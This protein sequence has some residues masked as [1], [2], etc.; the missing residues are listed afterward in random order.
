MSLAVGTRLG[1]YE[2]LAPLGAGGM[3]EV[4]RARDT[5]LDRDV[6][7]KILPEA[8]AADPE[9]LA[10]FQREAK[11]LA[12]LNHPNIGQI[13]GLE[14]SVPATA[15][16]ARI[17]GLVLELVEGDTL[18]AKL[19]GTGLPVSEALTIARQIADALDAAHGKAIV[20]RDLKPANIKITPSGTVKVLDFG[21][22]KAVTDDQWH[23]DLSH[24][25][26]VSALATRGGVIL[27]TAAYMSPEQA[28]GQVVDKRTDIWAFGCVLFE[29]LTGRG[30]FGR[31]TTSDTIAAVLEHEPDWSQCPAR[32]PPAVTR[33][34]RRCLEKNPERR[35]HDIADARLEIDEA[36]SPPT[37][38]VAST[39]G[40]EVW[41]VKPLAWSV[42]GALVGA[43]AAVIALTSMG[44]R[45][46]VESAPR[47][48]RAVNVTNSAAQEF[49]PA[50]SP[51]GKWVAYYSNEAGRTDLWVKFLDSGATSNLTANLNLE[52]P[53]R[54]GI[55][56]VA[57]SPDGSQIAF[58]ARPDPAQPQYDTWVIPAPVGGV[59]RKLLQVMQGLQWSPDGRQIICVRPGSTSGDTLVLTNSDGSNA[60][61]LV[62]AVPGR[63][64][65]WPAWSRDGQSVY[66]INTY[67]TW[68]TEPSETYRVAVS[69]GSPEPA[70]RSARRAIYPVPLPGGDF[71]FAGNPD[72]IDLGLWWKPAGTGAAQPLTVG[73]G[74][75]TEP[76][77]SA[78]GRRIV[79]T[80]VDVR[81]A[82]VRLPIAD[83]LNR[84]VPITDGHMGDIDPSLDPRTD[85]LV[86]SSARSGRRNLWIARADGNDAR[87]LTT[88]SAND[89]RPVFSPDGEQVAFVSDRSGRQAIWAMSAAGGA[90]KMLAE[91]IVLDSLTWSLD[92]T[93]VIFARPE[94]NRT[95][96]AAV[97][98]ADGRVEPI[99]TPA[100]ACC[101]AASPKAN[102]IAYLQPTILPAQGP[103]GSSSARLWLRFIDAEGR[104]LHT[105][106][107]DQQFANGFLSWS[108]DGKRLIGASVTAGG[109]SALWIVEP[110]ARQP[111][112]KFFD[113][114]A[115]GRPRGLTWTRDGASVIVANQEFPG[116]I[117]M[118]DVTR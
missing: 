41:R 78:D 53:A 17:R 29:M 6:A 88:E 51:D 14:E 59:P 13:Y 85:R 10:R 116:D 54:T 20:H 89:E 81:Q 23:P 108:P 66:F 107:P 48:S 101:P 82:L 32:T 118:F 71:V 104:P 109:A 1:Q 83:G 113:F 100:Q 37:K 31:A 24:S 35:L 4:Y 77:L 117:V 57:L 43:L 86:F 15:G 39:Q 21:L 36:S 74:E 33:L 52:L 70:V 25:P 75:Y 79:A 80:L 28:R 115:I 8:F 63:H 87:P 112:K 27:G 55:G 68:H 90:P 65:H 106:L 95:G 99:S 22:A 12:S 50:I 60:R 34:L 5:Q 105:D 103:S 45:V 114:P 9:R 76:R 111:Y 58:T 26:T 110:G 92:S 7:I 19:A 97:S 62:T 42:A 72:T 56:G 61:D 18:G 2:I 91:T 93:R 73:I 38:D 64:I 46:R 16:Q 84:M 3:G 67:D 44:P 30:T 49:G 102:V 69:G 11:T 47:L 96:L 94:G 40:E 98:V